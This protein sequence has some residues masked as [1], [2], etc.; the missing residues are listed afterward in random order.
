M[1]IR[2]YAAADAEA[3]CALWNAC[4]PLDR[5]NGDNFYRR[6]I[7]DVNFDPQKYLF[8]VDRGKPVGFVYG[9]KRRIP[10]EIAG[11]QPDQG[12]IA[13]MGV[14]PSRRGQGVGKALLDAVEG[15]L[16]A[17]GA[18]KIDVGPYATNYFCSGVDKDTYA[19]GVRFFTR[20]GYTAKGESFSMDIDLHGYQKPARYVEKKK[21]LQAAGYRFKAFE[22]GD[23]LGLFAFMRE[24]FGWWLPDVRASILAGRAEKTLILAQN[25]GGETV[26][27]VLRAMD[28][29]GERFGPFGT[30]PSLQGIG[31]GS[32]LFH[33]M[34]EN[35]T[36][37]R[38]FYTYFLWTSGRNVDIY[39]T[40]GM[41]IYRT[42]TMLG[43]TAADSGA[44]SSA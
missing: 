5:I 3:A 8:A 30:K 22:P 23:A 32:T 6:I 14:H 13:A 2:P 35:M 39:G 31:L 24:D 36:A 15:L 33:E 10:D 42:Y 20:R 26:G 16:A 12:W 9:V 1:E 34:M 11:L 44:G 40:W 28:G 41:K 43:K 25:A 18:K 21:A 29:T 4:L 19:P 37:N 38:I 7:Y 27:F 17:E